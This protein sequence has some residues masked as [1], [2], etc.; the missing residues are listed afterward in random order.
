MP[1]LGQEPTTCARL[2]FQQVGNDTLTANTA[3][4]IKGSPAAEWDRNTWPVL[5][6]LARNHPE[7]G[8]H[9]QSKAIFTADVER[10]W[11]C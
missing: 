7:S 9:F 2:S 11:S 10:A 1:L 6:D 5:D 3:V 4:S 8:I